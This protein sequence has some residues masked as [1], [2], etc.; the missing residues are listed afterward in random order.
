MVQG[1]DYRVPMSA[2]G[3][4]V[5]GA[6]NGY[7]A[8]QQNKRQ[9]ALLDLTTQEKEQ[10]M[11]HLDDESRMK[12]IAGFAVQIKPFLDAGDHA[13]AQR[14]FNQRISEIKSR[15]GNPEDSLELAPF[16][17]S[18][19]L[20]SAKGMVDSVVGAAQQ[21][22]YLK[23]GV[24]DELKVGRFRQI[25]LPDGTMASLDTATNQ[26]TTLA[27]APSID[28]SVIPEDMRDGVSKLPRDQQVKVVETFATPQAQETVDAKAKQD[29]KAMQ[30]A[31]STKRLVSELLSNE[32]GLRSAVG[33][34]DEFLPTFS[35]NTRD[36]EAALDDLRNLLTV[37]NLGLMSGV[38]S[39]SD[40][41]ILQSVG[42]NGLSGSD[43]RV[44]G[45][46]KRMAKALG[47]D[48]GGSRSGGSIPQGWS[49]NGDGTYTLPDG[50]RARRTR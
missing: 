40:I 2:R 24:P 43:D 22:G 15:G 19:D 4:D 20:E 12:S 1:V 37:D 17:M 3:L 8:G 38:L 30:V 42:S 23:G 16:L 25:T 35:D 33:A 50:R 49:D 46:L 11:Q 26:M 7:M 6:V 45:S 29:E 13:G 34:V 39:E 21:Q 18:G 32:D 44:I 31:D 48:V 41:K 28:L 5:T 9:N 27:E 14:V 47:V 10:R 36:A